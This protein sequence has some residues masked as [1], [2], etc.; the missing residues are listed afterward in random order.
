M[1]NPDQIQGT[2]ISE[3]TATA[4][5]TACKTFEQDD[6]LLVAILCGDG[7]HFGAGTNLGAMGAPC[8]RN[9]ID[10]GGTVPTYRQMITGLPE[11]AATF[12]TARQT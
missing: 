11:N 6:T 1:S 7:G 9:N 4:L 3:L 2:T 8:R 5:R 12:T 10:P